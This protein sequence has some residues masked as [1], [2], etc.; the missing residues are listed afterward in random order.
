MMEKRGNLSFHA[1]EQEPVGEQGLLREV[2]L[3]E[4]QPSVCVLLKQARLKARLDLA[5]IARTLRIRLAHLEAIEDGRFQELPGQAYASGFIRSYAE[6]LGLD[7]EAMVA[8]FHQEVGNGAT[9]KKLSFP[10]PTHETRRPRPWLVVIVL[11]LAAFA[12]GGWH[13]Y[14]KRHNGP[15]EKLAEMPTAQEQAPST[16]SDSN[17]TPPATQ[18]TSSTAAAPANQAGAANANLLWNSDGAQ[19][20]TSPPEQA[21]GAATQMPAAANPAPQAAPATTTPANAA[22]PNK[23][24]GS[25]GAAATAAEDADDFGLKVG[26]GGSVQAA[27]ASSDNGA[28]NAARTEQATNQNGPQIYGETV[29]P[30][31]IEISARADSWLQVQGPGNELLLTRILKSGDLY[32]VPDRKGLTLVTGNAGALEIKVDGQA[33]K[34]IGPI[35]VVRRNVPLDPDSLLAGLVNG[36]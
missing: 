15:V 34:P 25:S 30:V 17:A 9:E 36:Q 5:E 18:S 23:P 2:R 21:T 35:G 28:T 13:Y 32:R 27:A 8:R 24:G 29:G 3:V 19:P 16:T 10:T 14:A 12:Y 4:N 20:G 1:T 26:E 22:D 7:R 6:H 31:R 33:V 11:L